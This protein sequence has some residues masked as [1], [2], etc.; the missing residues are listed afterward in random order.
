V[1]LSVR[2]SP[3]SS[4]KLLDH[5]PQMHLWVQ[6]DLSLQVYLHTQCNMATKCISQL[7]D[8]GLGINV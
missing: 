6:L 4:P 2:W 8:H 7:H 1:H 5:G 3:N